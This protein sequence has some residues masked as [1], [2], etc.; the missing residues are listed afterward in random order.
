MF[1]QRK[2]LRRMAAFMVLVWLFALSS[3][4]KEIKTLMNFSIKTSA[5]SKVL[6]LVLVLLPSAAIALNAKPEPHI[7]LLVPQGTNADWRDFAYLAAVPAASKANGGN[8]A[9]IAL[10]AEDSIPSE[11]N[12]Y[13]R[14]FK[15][16]EIYHLG[17][18]SLSGA[19]AV[20]K[21]REL[22]CT[23]A[24]QAANRHA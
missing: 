12:D 18:A 14:R 17:A 4:R 11:V 2:R 9:V 20:G 21:L 22:S 23:N 24:D 19:P 6:R 1:G 3:A 8:A 7:A 15:P 13:L 10:E 16:T 5:L